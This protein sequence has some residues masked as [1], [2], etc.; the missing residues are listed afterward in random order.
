MTAG[1]GPPFLRCFAR[2]T[3]EA[4]KRKLSFPVNNNHSRVYASEIKFS[5]FDRCT[6]ETAPHLVR[7]LV[8]QFF[9]L[10]R[11]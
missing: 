11:E 5:L 7:S 2:V 3:A 6:S 1:I 10:L 8:R 9:Y 4:T